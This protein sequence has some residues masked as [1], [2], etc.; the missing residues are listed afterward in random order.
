MRHFCVIFCRKVYIII[1]ICMN[2][3]R[4]LKSYYTKTLVYQHFYYL[5]CYNIIIIIITILILLKKYLV[6][7]ILYPQL[8]V[9]FNV[10]LKNKAC[11]FILNFIVRQRL[12]INSN[13][14]LTQLKFLI[15]PAPV[16]TRL[17][18]L[19]CLTQAIASQA[20]KYSIKKLDKVDII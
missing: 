6:I 4:N 8:L 12:R 5:L 14:V 10:Y 19:Q 9:Y 7:I 3:K 20:N 15:Q 16:S 2:H 17:S 11:V 18:T 13:F 1:I